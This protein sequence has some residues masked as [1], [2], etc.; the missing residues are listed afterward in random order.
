MEKMRKREREMS[1][2]GGGG[3]MV[4]LLRNGWMEQRRELGLTQVC[5]GVISFQTRR[6]KERK[7]EEGELGILVPLL[8]PYLRSD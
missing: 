3:S 5:D 1:S 2:G 8:F 6:R 4:F 7:E